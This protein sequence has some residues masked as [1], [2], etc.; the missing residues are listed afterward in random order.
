MSLEDLFNKYTTESRL[1]M[2]TIKNYRH[3]ILFYL[4]DWLQKPVT[5]ITK[6]MVEERFYKIR[7]KGMNGGKPTFSQATKTMRILSALMNYAMADELIES[8]PVQV[9]KLKRVDRSIRKRDN[10]LP[11]IKVRELLEKSAQDV[12]PVTLAVHL[13]IYT[14]LRK[15]EAL[16]LKW[17][18][19]KQVEGVRCIIVKDT[20]NS[21]PHYVPM[22]EEI[23]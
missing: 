8:N 17:D 19:L 14:G 16:R 1:K 7:D 5:S 15:N 21:R 23:Q 6:Q 12:H 18:D 20:K 3:V 11:A 4:N 22:T 13:M 10:Y 9:L 2:N